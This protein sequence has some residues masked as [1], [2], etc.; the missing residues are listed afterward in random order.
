MPHFAAIAE[1]DV[2]A[3]VNRKIDENAQKYPVERPQP[4]RGPGMARP[5]VGKS[6]FSGFEPVDLGR[7]SVGERSCDIEPVIESKRETANTISPLPRRCAGQ[8]ADKDARCLP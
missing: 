4:N 7:A 3:V 2:L 8:D 5:P 1:I 6:A